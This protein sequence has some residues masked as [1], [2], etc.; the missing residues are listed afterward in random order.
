[1]VYIKT[2]YQKS[3]HDFNMQS[4]FSPIVTSRYRLTY[5]FIL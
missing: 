1:M 2:E 5:N 4:F 3:L